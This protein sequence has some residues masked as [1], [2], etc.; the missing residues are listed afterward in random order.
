MLS[1]FSKTWYGAQITATRNFR[2]VRNYEQ[3]PRS[4]YFP[5]I[6]FTVRAFL[7]H[8]EAASF[9]SAS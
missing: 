2:I 5:V 1:D 8:A 4:P 6:T 3:S 7:H 9:P